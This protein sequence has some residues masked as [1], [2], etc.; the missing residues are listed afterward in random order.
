MS[1]DAAVHAVPH[2]FAALFEP[3]LKDFL[4]SD[5][6]EGAHKTRVA[7][8][9]LRAVLIGFSPLISRKLWTRLQR[10][11]R[12]YFRLIGRVRD[13][14]ILYLHA[15]GRAARKAAAKEAAALRKSVRSDVLAKGIKE[16]PDDLE[17]L[18][19]GKGWRRESSKAR[20]IGKAGI[21]HVAATALQNAYDG[22]RKFP[23]DLCLLPD[24]DLHEFRKRLKTLRYLGEHF[25]A[26][27]PGPAQP[28]FFECLSR[29]QDALGDLND[30][31]LAHQSGL[32]GVSTN[33]GDVLQVSDL[34]QTL[35][36]VALWWPHSACYDAT[37]ALHDR[38]QTPAPE[39]A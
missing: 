38:P 12:S 9:R 18:F 25:A 17:K 29:L 33:A 13:A 11:S 34:W 27:W 1:A 32:A 8:R 21:E 3:A 2:W 24:E 39:P 30:A 5:A 10:R 15:N 16:F 19:K 26:L 14:D 28:Q 4:K 23:L 35:V 36:Q 31:K 6:P 20:Q 37:A 7:L 22:C